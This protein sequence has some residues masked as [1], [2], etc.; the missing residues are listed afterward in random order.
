MVNALVVQT[1]QAKNTR[2]SGL[3]GLKIGKILK[4]YGS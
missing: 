4:I 1:V 2:C 3:M